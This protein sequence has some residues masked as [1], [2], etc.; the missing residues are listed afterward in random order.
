[1]YDQPNKGQNNGARGKINRTEMSMQ[2][3]LNHTADSQFQKTTDQVIKK[4]EVILPS[5]LAKS[6]AEGDKTSQN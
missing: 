5:T 1:M 2:D 4:G 3:N 6:G